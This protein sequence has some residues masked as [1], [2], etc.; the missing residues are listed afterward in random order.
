MKS[1]NLV[2]TTCRFP[3][4]AADGGERYEWRDR[5]GR[6][7]HLLNCGSWVSGRRE[8]CAGRRGRCKTLGSVHPPAQCGRRQ[9]SRCSPPQLPP[10][11]TIHRR[12]T[13]RQRKTAG[14]DDAP[15]PSKFPKHH[16]TVHLRLKSQIQEL[17]I[18]RQSKFIYRLDNAITH[19][20][21]MRPERVVVE[22]EETVSLHLLLGFGNVTP[23]P[24]VRMIGVD[25]D[26]V[27]VTVR[28]PPR[29]REGVSFAQPPPPLIDRRGKRV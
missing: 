21:P 24:L 12:R 5:S 8:R 15:S 9:H 25:I 16:V 17:P 10:S 4:C 27:E 2:A 26:P 3:T 28:K 11:R 7:I 14:A 20:F 22:N 23:D 19:E 18:F 6:V 13:W 1:T 29:G